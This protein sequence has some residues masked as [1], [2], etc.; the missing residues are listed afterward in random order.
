[1]EICFKI[2]LKLRCHD[3]QKAVA[4]SDVHLMRL[5]RHALYYIQLQRPRQQ[6]RILIWPSADANKLYQIWMVVVGYCIRIVRDWFTPIQLSKLKSKHKR[7]RLLSCK[8]T[9]SKYVVRPESEVMWPDQTRQKSFHQGKERRQKH[10]LTINDTYLAK[11]MQQVSDDDTS[12]LKLS[13][14]RFPTYRYG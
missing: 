9:M 3:L 10:G 2:P 8:S 11:F 13:S 5:K 7:G 6:L 4:N 1:M 12:L 14:T